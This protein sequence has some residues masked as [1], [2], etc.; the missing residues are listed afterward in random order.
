[1]QQGVIVM[2]LRNWLYLLLVL[3]F[4][5]IYTACSS[6][7]DS[8]PTTPPTVNEAQVLAEYLEAN[9]DFINTA[10][11]AI[12]AAQDV[13]D[14]QLTKP[15]KTYIIDIRSS[16]D[17]QNKGHIDGAVNVALKD[18][19]THVKGINATAYEKIVIACYSGQTAGMATAFLR[20]LGYN[21][22]F[23]LKWGMSSWNSTACTSWSM[24]VVGNNYTGFV[25]TA[26]AKPAA[27]SLPTISTGKTTGLAILEE[28]INQVLAS[29]DPFGDI[30][31]AWGTVTGNLSNYFILNYW[32]ENHYNLGH[33][34]GA[35]QYTPKTDLKL[36][37]N[38][39][40][41]PTNKTIV[42]YCYTGQT[43]AQVVSVLKLLGYD[44]KTL[45]FGVN[46]MNYDWMGTN[47]LTQW[48]QTEV[49]EFP[50]VTGQ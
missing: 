18:I 48:K 15:D 39:K 11:P 30:K 16:A 6:D 29:A 47:G 13:R 43:S 40:T 21:N 28:R 25:T 37:T 24:S 5:F 4:L 3:P 45:L 23:S 12:I 44:I 7:E 1:M 19:V 34:P 35:V 17:F 27:G 33:L 38:L 9:G 50:I 26:T 49:K 20:L 41:L 31:I 46:V 8:N 2:K 14:M 36:S 42:L 32:P 22:V 10:A